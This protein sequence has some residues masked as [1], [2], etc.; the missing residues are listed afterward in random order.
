M[1]NLSGFSLVGLEESSSK[2][3]DATT[4]QEIAAHPQESWNE[5][6]CSTILGL[7]RQAEPPLNLLFERSIDSDDTDESESSKD[8]GFEEEKKSDAEG[9][10]ERQYINHQC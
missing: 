5:K 1:L 2:V 10:N 7:L 9:D 6:N 8:E 4:S 3:P